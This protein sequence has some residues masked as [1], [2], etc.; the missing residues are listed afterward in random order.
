MTK[1]FPQIILI[2][3]FLGFCWLAMQAVHELGHVLGALLTGAD[4][5]KVYLHPLTFSRTELVSNNPHPLIVVW[6]GPIVGSFL[7]LITFLIA[8]A[9]KTPGIYLFRFFAGFCLI[10]NGV[11]I[12]FG[13]DTGALDTGLMLSHGV[14]R[15]QM[16]AFGLGAIVP[17][18]LLWHGQGNHFGLGSSKGVVDKRAVIVSVSLFIFVIVTE[19]LFSL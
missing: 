12:A 17:G 19:V 18:F 10:A 14:A 7:P 5:Q 11:Y 13:P 8:K 6:L 9:C 4:I 1:R 2:F 16:V 15:W 3:T